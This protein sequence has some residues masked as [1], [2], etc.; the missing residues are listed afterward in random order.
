MFQDILNSTAHR[1]SPLPHGPWLMMQQWRQILFMHQR[2]PQRTV[3]PHLPPGLELDTY[4]GDAWISVIPFR[5]SKV[6]LRGLPPIPFLNSFL[7]VNVR[8]YVKRNG[9][10]GVYFFSL[11]ADK[12]PAVVG[13]RMATL[14]YYYA[15]ISMKMRDGTVSFR[16]ERKGGRQPGF[17]S[18]VY[19]PTGERFYPEKGSLENWLL[20]RYFL[21]TYKN[22]KLYRCGIH[23]KKWELQQA[24]AEMEKQ[25]VAPFLYNGVI[26]ADSPAHYAACQTTLI[27][28]IR[29]EG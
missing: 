9:K 18:G 19:Q 4:E 3:E 2:L 29:K 11:D 23:H 8:T 27:W 16:S 17:L 26:G 6:R 25:V 1:N 22:G 5:V 15:D 24:E 12:L 20:K 14:P 13:A 21:W 28:M 7:Q 10:R